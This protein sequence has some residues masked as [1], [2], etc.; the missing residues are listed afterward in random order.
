[1]TE[2]SR[3]HLPPS[4]CRPSSDFFLARFPRLFQVLKPILPAPST[5]S[6]FN[7]FTVLGEKHEFQVSSAEQRGPVVA[8]TALKLMM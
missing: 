7:F 2:G 6:P 5:S 8:I 4:P 3:S 1:M